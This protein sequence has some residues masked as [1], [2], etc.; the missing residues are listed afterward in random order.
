MTHQASGQRD[1]EYPGHQ[2]TRDQLL[3]PNHTR[4]KAVVYTA[5]YEPMPL[6]KSRTWTNA[7]TFHSKSIK[8]EQQ[9]CMEYL[10]CATIPR[11]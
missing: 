11:T 2:G 10:L 1:K 4:P 8:I 5:L 6:R 9:T 7:N 3:G